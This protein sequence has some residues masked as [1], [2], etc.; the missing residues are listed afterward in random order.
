MKIRYDASVIRNLFGLFGLDSSR[1]GLP[2]MTF[3]F[4]A[5]KSTTWKKIRQL[6]ENRNIRKW[7]ANIWWVLS[8]FSRYSKSVG[9]VHFPTSAK[10][11]VGIEELFLEL[12]QRMMDRALLLE[13]QKATELT[14]TNSMRR[15]IVIVDDDEPPPQKKSCCG[16]T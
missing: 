5:G 12:T 6:H 10:Q 9:A 14:R 13:R 8:L 3:Q 2:H 7:V 15:N 4:P 16:T 1:F 11:N